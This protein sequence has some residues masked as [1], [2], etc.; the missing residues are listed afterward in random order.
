VESQSLT[1][2][3]TETS[4]TPQS[5]VE[6]MPEH[7]VQGRGVLRP[8]INSDA[9]TSDA[10]TSGALNR[11]QRGGSSQPPAPSKGKHIDLERWFSTCGS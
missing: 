2:T 6:E 5:T 1:V 4:P 10:H 7:R 8:I 3:G 11:T 9:L